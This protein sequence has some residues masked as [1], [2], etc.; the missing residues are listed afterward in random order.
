MTK[1]AQRTPLSDWEKKVQYITSL[2][3]RGYMEGLQSEAAKTILDILKS[4]SHTPT[5]QLRERHQRAVETLPELGQ[6]IRRLTNLAYATAPNEVRETLAKEQFIDSLID[7]DMRLRIKQARPTDL[8]D[9]IRHAVEL[10]AFN[11]AESKRIEGQGFLR[12]ASENRHSADN[13]TI[14]Q[15]WPGIMLLRKNRVQIVKNL[16]NPNNV[17]DSLFSDRVFTE[18]MRDGVQEP[19]TE[20]KNRMILDT[21]H[22]RGQ[23][24]VKSLYNA[25]QETGNDHLADL[26]LPYARI[27]EQKKILMTQKD[28]YRLCGEKRG[29]VFIMNNTFSKTSWERHG[30]EVDL[31][32]LQGMFEFLIEERN[33][34]KNWKEI[35]CIVLIVMS[36]GSSVTDQ[37]AIAELCVKVDNQKLL[38]KTCDELDSETFH[39]EKQTQKN[40]ASSDFLIVYATPEGKQISSKGKGSA[41]YPQKITVSEVKSNLRK[42]FYFFPGVY[43][44][45]PQFFEE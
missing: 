11:K 16:A 32:T 13:M 31:K 34:I 19:E 39:E 26:L 17:A 7:S 5:T 15:S 44:D 12:T 6:D 30:S 42:K 9:A 4:S 33:K 20:E 1:S 22:R 41:G 10:E 23:R 27:I 18:E 3:D 24:S 21:L 45:S 40:H 36:Q 38:P 25:F 28:V 2:S 43:G 35:E 8:N 37:D 29:K 14:D